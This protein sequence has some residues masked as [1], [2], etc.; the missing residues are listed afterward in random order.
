MEDVVDLLEERAAQIPGKLLL[1]WEP[2]NGPPREWS[3]QEF[4]DDVRRVAAG[5]ALRGVVPGERVLMHGDNCPEL[6]LTWFACAWLGA[7]C[8]VIN[9]KS[10]TDEIAYV[11][12]HTGAAGIITQKGLPGQVTLAEDGLRWSVTLGGPAPDRFDRLAGTAVAR[13]RVDP[14]SAGSMMFTSGTTA[15]PKA[16]LW[17]RANALWAAQASCRA[18]GLLESDTALVFVPLYHVVGLA[19]SV[20]PA[21]QA[22]A[23]IV[24]QPRF[25]ASRFWSVAL[26]RQATFA[27][28]VQF[29]TAVLFRQPVPAAHHFRLWCNS[30]WL[31]EYEKHFRVPIIGWWGMTELVAPGILGRPGVAQHAGTIGFGAPGYGLRIA[32]EPGSQSHDA[33]SVPAPGETGELEIRGRR[34]ETIFSGYFGDDAATAASFTPDGWFRTGDRVQVLADGSIRFLERVRDV[35]KTGGEGVS[36][37]EVER[38]IRQVAGVSDVSVVGRPDA[39]LGEVGVAF[40]VVAEAASA[41]ADTTPSQTETLEASIFAAC[42]AQLAAFKVPK[43]I[44]FLASLPLVGIN[45]VAK[46][47]LRRLAQVTPAPDPTSHG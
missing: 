41:R 18:T 21:L 28:H 39:L 23:A 2:F 37:A 44:R 46:G 22:G 35:I 20:L 31:P 3:R 40:L 13:V 6:L 47:E 36:P 24:L 25:S 43:E 9:P 4:L 16:V 19:W 14:A 26:A 17:S 34:G 11:A 45:K 32:G 12:H 7:V 38:V 1:A 27:S 29:S 15:R 33:D 30:T 5:L 42:R 10:S 8:V